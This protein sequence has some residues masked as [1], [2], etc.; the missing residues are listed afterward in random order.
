MQTTLCQE[1]LVRF[2]EH[3]KDL[4]KLVKLTGDRARLDAKA[5]DTYIVYKT[6]SGQIVKEYANG[7]IVPVPETDF[8]HD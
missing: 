2:V 4:H 6:D 8:S 7:Q 1:W 5:N 3:T